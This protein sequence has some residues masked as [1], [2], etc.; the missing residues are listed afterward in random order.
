MKSNVRYISILN[1]PNFLSILRLAGTPFLFWLITFENLTWFITTYLV[2]GFTDYLDGKLARLWNQA[3]DLGAHL[4]TAADVLFYLS[5]A[6]FLY[7]LF[8]AFVQP[9]LMFLYILMGIIV[10]SVF[11]SLYLFKKVLFFHTHL[12]RSAGVFVFFTMAASFFTDTTWLIGLT[13]FLY[14]LAFLEFIVIYFLRGDVSPD[15]RSIFNRKIP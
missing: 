12:S 2:L 11:I 3:S 7:Y 6:W 1:L 9:N 13:I 8:P 4:D 15:T 5:T 14:S 10:V